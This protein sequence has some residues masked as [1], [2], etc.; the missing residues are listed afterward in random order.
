VQVRCLKRNTMGAVKVIN[1][2]KLA[3]QFDGVH[4]VYLDDVIATMDPT[5]L[6]MTSNTNFIN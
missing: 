3:W 1:A 6:D 4:H 5:G 2:S